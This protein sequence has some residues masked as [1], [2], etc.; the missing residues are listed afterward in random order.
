MCFGQTI[1]QSKICNII[2]LS[3]LFKI[4]LKCKNLAIQHKQQQ[5][6]K[7]I[8]NTLAFC[9]SAADISND[10][11]IIYCAAARAKI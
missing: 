11:H 4:K 6:G 5:K 7:S 8:F 2:A 9:K 1:K 10:F 3:R